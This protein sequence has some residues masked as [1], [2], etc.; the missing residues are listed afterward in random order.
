MRFR[1]HP[2]TNK[3]DVDRVRS[4]YQAQ[5]DSTSWYLDIDPSDESRVKALIQD[6]GYRCSWQGEYWYCQ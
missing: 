4:G 3:Q 5:R 1:F 2:M 6:R